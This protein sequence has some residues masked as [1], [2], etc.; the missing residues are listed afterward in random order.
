MVKYYLATKKEM[1]VFETIWMKLQNTAWSHLYVELK[2]KKIKNS[3]SQIQRTDWWMPAAGVGGGGG[4]WQWVKYM[5][6]ILKRKMYTALS[7]L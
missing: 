3:K 2:K 6:E 5:K 4:G 1:L 7:N